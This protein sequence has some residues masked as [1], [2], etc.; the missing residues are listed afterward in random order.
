MGPDW[1]DPAI[2]IGN[3]VYN[4]HL[5]LTEIG[6]RFRMLID[7]AA[8]LYGWPPQSFR[9]DDKVDGVA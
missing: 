9:G 6:G 1:V 8:H 5:P 7:W 4:S 3:R 2:T